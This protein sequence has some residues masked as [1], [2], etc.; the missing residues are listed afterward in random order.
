MEAA[1][2]CLRNNLSGDVTGILVSSQL[3]LA[4]P[5]LPAAAQSKLRSV[6]DL[7]ERIRVR[8]ET[9]GQLTSARHSDEGAA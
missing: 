2:R 5:S 7:A 8:L 3:A 4:E 9:P 6:C 1:T